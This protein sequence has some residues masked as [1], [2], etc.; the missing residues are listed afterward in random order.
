MISY[1]EDFYYLF[2]VFSIFGKEGLSDTISVNFLIR[3]LR[4]AVNPNYPNSMKLELV[5]NDFKKA[6]SIKDFNWKDQLLE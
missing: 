3:N 6:E 4:D 2:R 5:I 1:K